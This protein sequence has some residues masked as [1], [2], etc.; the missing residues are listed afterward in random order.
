MPARKRES[1]VTEETTI[2]ESV[3]SN[4]VGEQTANTSPVADEPIEDNDDDDD[5]DDDED[6]DDDA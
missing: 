6:T 2:S 4:D 1:Y 3:T 5:D